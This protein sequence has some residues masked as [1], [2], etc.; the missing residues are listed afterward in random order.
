ML[1]TIERE[2][3]DNFLDELFE[4][5]P[6]ASNGAV[7]QCINWD[8]EN[9]KFTFVDLEDELD[10]DD[11]EAVEVNGWLGTS[12]CRKFE[13]DREKAEEGFKKFLKAF[14]ADSFSFYGL[15]DPLDACEY[16]AESLDGIVQYALFGEL[17]YG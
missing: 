16:D 2:I 14:Y 6:E 12:H 5:Y 15:R 13:L 1:V 3:A 9:F 4:N 11:P 8:Y 7:L 10:E 17:V